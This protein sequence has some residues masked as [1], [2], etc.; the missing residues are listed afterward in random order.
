[1]VSGTLDTSKDCQGSVS[2][3]IQDVT[4]LHR[5]FGMVLIVYVRSSL[6]F[7]RY[8]SANQQVS[9]RIERLRREQGTVRLQSSLR[10]F[11]YKSAPV[12]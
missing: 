12:S 2:T 7:N 8:S 5:H 11:Q 9:L 10:R 3:E 1:M 6:S 4:A